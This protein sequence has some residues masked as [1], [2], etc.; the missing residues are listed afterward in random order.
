MNKLFLPFILSVLLCPSV[1]PRHDTFQ[2]IE[3]YFSEYDSI[4]RA[5]GGRLCGINLRAPFLFISP[6]RKVYANAADM[7]GY[8][9]PSAS[10]FVGSFPKELSPANSTINFGGRKWVMVMLPVPENRF[11]RQSLFMHEVFHFWQ[12]SLRLPLHSYQNN[13]LEEKWARIYLKLEWNALDKAL[14]ADE[15]E[16]QQHLLAAIA[17]RAYR[18]SLYP[19]DMKDELSF[20]QD[21][22]LPQ[23]VGMRLAARS[24]EEWIAELHRSQEEYARKDNLVRTFAY[25]SG[26]LYGFFLAQKQPDWL[27]RF[28]DGDDLGLLLQKTY[29][30]SLPSSGETYIDSVRTVYDYAALLAQ[31]TAREEKRNAWIAEQKALFLSSETLTL[32]LSSIQMSFDPNGVKQLGD[33]GTLYTQIRLVDDWGILEVRQNGCLITPD[34]RFIRVPCPIIPEGKVIETENWRLELKDGY[35][36]VRDTTGGFRVSMLSEN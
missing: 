3:G 16:R 17:F 2:Q 15:S 25:H 8:L 32:P 14:D 13:H 18:H 19:D 31:E 24:R 33:V 26:A 4:C 29:A 28:R 35:R 9:E 7:E 6:E 27:T 5:D 1:F 30:L 34:W 21:E 36:C 11:A 23:Y 10:L 20:E 12:D 22:G